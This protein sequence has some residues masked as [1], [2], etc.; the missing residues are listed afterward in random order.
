MGGDA[1]WDLE[2]EIVQICNIDYEA[3]MDQKYENGKK[4]LTQ[5]IFEKYFDKILLHI[6]KYDDS[7]R[8]AYQVL[9][10]FILFSGSKMNDDIKKKIIEATNWQEEK[11]FWPS[12]MI[13]DRKFYL[14]DLKQKILNHQ[15]G[16][17]TLLAILDN[18]F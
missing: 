7:K 8:L 15:S 12:E 10:Y 16:I 13:E 4:V 18:Q 14:N 3:Y 9:G 17:I 11:D 6:E 1:Q 5:E 2:E